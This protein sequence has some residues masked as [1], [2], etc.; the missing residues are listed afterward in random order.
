MTATYFNRS[1]SRTSPNPSGLNY[2]MAHL[3]SEDPTLT[4]EQYQS[5]VTEVT[6]PTVYPLQPTSITNVSMHL[7]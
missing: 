3:N 1:F 6:A 4:H 2:L 5:M 7:L